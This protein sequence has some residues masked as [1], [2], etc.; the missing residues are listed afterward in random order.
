MSL[1][2]LL[3]EP[4]QEIPHS[5]NAKYKFKAEKFLRFFSILSPIT[6]LPI[7]NSPD[8]SL[9]NL[10][11]GLWK[12]RG[13]KASRPNLSISITRDALTLLAALF[14]RNEIAH[15]IPRQRAR[16]ARKY[17]LKAGKELRE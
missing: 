5:D 4:G 8:D 6:E 17:R 3:K 12:E 9:P 13:G 16:R 15:F 1:A 11:Y 14:A 7:P 10:I 2:S